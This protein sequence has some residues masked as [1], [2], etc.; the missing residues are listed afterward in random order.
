MALGESLPFLVSVTI[1]VQKQ[2][3]QREW[4]GVSSY[5]SFLIL[6]NGWAAYLNFHAACAPSQK[7]LFAERPQRHKVIRFRIS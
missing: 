5:L 7:G 6:I 4:T 1:E 3:R 2:L